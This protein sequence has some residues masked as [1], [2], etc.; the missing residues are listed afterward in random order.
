MA[1]YETPRFPARISF[2]VTGGPGFYTQI[3]E[4]VAAFEQR[5]G[6]RIYPRHKWDLS[7]VPSQLGDWE[8]IRAFFM[9]VR[10]RL[11][12]FRFKDW[13]DFEC[14]H[15]GVDIGVVSGLTSTTFQLVKRYV[16][17]S[18]YLDR[19]ITK[20]LASP[21]ELK[22]SGVTLALSADYTLDTTTGVVTTTIPRTAA[23]LTW[24]GEF[25]VPVR[26]DTDDLRPTIVARNG[27]GL[28]T[29]WAGIPIKEI[30]V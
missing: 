24:A 30:R 29:D 25:D 2:G 17:G 6:A 7:S 15:S 12:G 27:Q 1:F 11:H 23:N 3:A 14:S 5:N 28:V 19:P 4:S 8:V 18:Q 9:T 20:P 21:F 16:S 22:D 10:G 13:A 26:F